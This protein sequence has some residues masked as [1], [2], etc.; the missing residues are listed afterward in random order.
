[1]IVFCQAA[2]QRSYSSIPITAAKTSTTWTIV[3]GSFLSLTSLSLEYFFLS[4]LGNFVLMYFEPACVFLI[5]QYGQSV[6]IINLSSGTN[7]ATSRF[8]SVLREQPFNPIYNPRSRRVYSSSTVPVNECTTPVENLLLF[9]FNILSKS[10]SVAL[11]CK[12]I[13]KLNSS[14][15]SKCLGNTFN[16]VSLSAYSNLS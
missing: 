7:F 9:S 2:W 12:Y 3:H 16:W 1:M 15:S 10:P 13:G 11:E 14:V 8:S 6:S 4:T 5:S